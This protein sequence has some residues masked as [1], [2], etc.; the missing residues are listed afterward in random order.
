MPDL[1]SYH[2]PE[3]YATLLAQTSNHEMR[4]LHDDGEYRHLRFQEP[5]TSLW[6]WDLITWPGSLAIRGDIGQGFIF[7]RTENM[8]QFFDH[9]QGAG[10]INAGYWA[11]KLEH[12]CSS[13]KKY[14][15]E[16]LHEHAVDTIAEWDMHDDDRTDALA[17]FEAWWDERTDEHDQRECVRDFTFID[18]DDVKHEFHDTWE[19]T[20]TDYDYHFILALHA[21]L[22]GAKK[23]H[24]R[25]ALTAGETNRGED[26]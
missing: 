7:T 12:G 13:V 8:L 5:G 6:H 23:Y 25:E 3:Q 19:W 26:A 2:Y 17:V 18:S 11:E 9:G 22:W 24:A 21:I 14:S 16:K 20:S 10:W 4:V 1:E 15:P